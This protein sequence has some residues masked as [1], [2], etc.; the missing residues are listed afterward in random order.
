[1]NG[2]P[3]WLHTFSPVKKKIIVAQWVILET[4]GNENVTFL[5]AGVNNRLTKWF[6]NYGERWLAYRRN[7]EDGEK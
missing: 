2:E 4:V 1:M 5:R 7:P 6:C 3:V